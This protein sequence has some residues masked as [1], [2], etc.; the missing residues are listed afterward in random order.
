MAILEE[1]A[2]RFSGIKGLA[3]GTTEKLMDGERRRIVVLFLDLVGFTRLG[4]FLDHEI[5]HRVTSRVMGLLSAVVRSY[6]GYVDKFEG[7]R[8]MVLFGARVA[9][10]NDG[11]RAVS[12]AL[13]LL[14]LLAE[15]A[16]LLPEGG[17]PARVG[18][19]CGPVT[20]APDAGGHLTA[21]GAP[22]NLASRLEELAVPGSVLVEQAVMKECGD[23]FLWRDEGDLTVRGLASPVH[24]YV[25]LEPNRAVPERWHRL[26]GR[27]GIL[28]VGRDDEL[29]GLSGLLRGCL[30]GQGNPVL[31][32]ITGEPGIGKSRLLHEFLAG[33]GDEARVLHGHTDQFAQ[34]PLH[35]WTGLFRRHL[36]GQGRGTREGWNVTLA[37]IADGCPNRETAQS[38]TQVTPVLAGLFCREGDQSHGGRNPGTRNAAAIKIL[39]EALCASSPLVLALEDLHWIDE[40]SLETLRLILSAASRSGPLMVVTTERPPGLVLA[41]VVPAVCRFPLEPLVNDDVLSLARRILGPDGAGGNTLDDG[42]AHLIIQGARG[43][44]FFAEELTLGLIDSRSIK[45]GADGAWFLT[46]LPGELAI[47]PS[48]Q[49]LVQARIDRLSERERRV[50]QFASVQGNQFRADVLEISVHSHHPELDVQGS[51]SA[52]EEAGFL[53]RGEGPVRSF[54]HDLVQR[55]AFETLLRHNRR[56]IHRSVALALE[57]LFSKSAPAISLTLLRHWEAADEPG[58]ILELAP[59]AMQVAG[60][61]GQ[62]EE[63]LRIADK[64]ITM[65]EN[66]ATDQEFKARMTALGTKQSLLSRT[67]RNH[68][69]LEV[70]GRMYEEAAGDPEWEAEALRAMAIAY[71]EDGLVDRVEPLLQ[72][73]LEKACQSGIEELQGRVLGSL[74]NYHS[75]TGD[76]ETAKGLYH[77]AMEIQH[78][79][80]NRSQVA[81]LYSNIANLFSRLGAYAES[82]RYYR[83]AVEV[84][85]ELGDRMSLGYA[86][87]GL[88]ICL[89]RAG[90][91]NGA[92]ECFTGALSAQTDT[93]NR[94][95]QAAVLT[96]LGTL[97]KMRGDFE[98]SLDYRTRSL[99]MAVETRSLASEAIAL[100]NIGNLRRL[101]G[102][103]EE[104]GSYCERALRLSQSIRDGI[105]SCFCESIRG[106]AALDM[107][108]PELAVELQSRATII[109]DENGIPP[110]VVDDYHELLERMESSGLPTV[111]PSGWGS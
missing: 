87:N 2:R 33:V 83:M 18:I 45:V 66:G 108:D 31:A 110:G 59:C 6:G 103:P 55:A 80:G 14:S 40:P 79:L 22:V 54:R 15:L 69:A 30:E 13:R 106:L 88:A 56:L 17:L 23:L 78:R 86:L 65:T 73:A 39:A 41:D 16:P 53:T 77:K 36:G 26:A 27:S 84:H 38:L 90:D 92:E 74:A 46:V 70:V 107:N 62:I 64:I 105:T 101:M 71:Q 24:G 29:S 60:G 57:S 20:V 52:L 32:Q 63:A 28:M 75:D 47:P 76:K 58:R 1:G 111:R 25:P 21:I 96:N 4:T 42:A 9:A 91:I 99:R 44:P 12:C 109:V 94:R 100:V 34:P 35:L 93:G 49:S 51:V 10:E 43:N 5:L 67:G 72:Q 50:L 104:T 82:E 98:T 97:A 7:D 37:S 68:E 89:A 19:A 95:E 61:G 102:H 48:V 8:I 81:A 11:A 85:S 3:S